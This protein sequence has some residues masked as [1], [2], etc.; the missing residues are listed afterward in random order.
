MHAHTHTCHTHPAETRGM[1]EAAWAERGRGAGRGPH[2]PN[3]GSAWGAFWPR[4]TRPSAPAEQARLAAGR[5][6][7]PACVLLPAALGVCGGCRPGRPPD[8]HVCPHEPLPSSLVRREPGAW[9]P[10]SAAFIHRKAGQCRGDGGKPPPECPRLS[11]VAVT[12][13]GHPFS[14][15]RKKI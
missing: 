7:R 4:E 11:G 6:A 9:T 10:A 14:P 12:E 3:Q 2:P 15:Q 1:R 8:P 5:G 13:T